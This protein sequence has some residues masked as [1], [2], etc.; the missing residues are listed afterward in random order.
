MSPRDG[1]EQRQGPRAMLEAG[2]VCRLEMRTPV[3]V[4]DISQSGVLVESDTP[5]PVGT[6]ALL[7]TGL[8]A[9]PFAS[10]VQVRR[11]AAAPAANAMTMLG[12]AFTLMDERNRRTL[13]AFLRKASE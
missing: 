7:R 8:G 10:F 2:F 9:M 1:T 6:P 5:L 3:R 12:M 4:V 13:D 11:T